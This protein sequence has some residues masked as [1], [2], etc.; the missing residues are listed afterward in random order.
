MSTIMHKLQYQ[1]KRKGMSQDD[2]AAK[3]GMSVHGYRK[4]E[5]CKRKLSIETAL[6]I[7]KILDLTQLE[8]ILEVAN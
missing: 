1:R 8:D 7:V 2:M 3:L 6:K 4:Y 5:Q